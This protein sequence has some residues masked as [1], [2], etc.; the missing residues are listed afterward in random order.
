MILAHQVLQLSLCFRSVKEN[1]EVQ[2]MFSGFYQLTKT[3]AAFCYG[4]SLSVREMSEKLND[5]LTAPKT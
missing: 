4:H 3:P 5:C 1:L 2:E